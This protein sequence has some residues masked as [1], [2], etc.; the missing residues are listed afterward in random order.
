MGSSMLGS[1]G[2]QS[3]PMLKIFF[4][5]SLSEQVSF[6]IT[7]INRMFCGCRQR[8]LKKV[9]TCRW[10]PLDSS[11]RVETVSRPGLLQSVCHK[12]DN[13]FL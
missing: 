7:G 10:F 5:A 1:G 6:N 9:L 4:I 13:P 11:S 8:D 2:R 3:S 12:I